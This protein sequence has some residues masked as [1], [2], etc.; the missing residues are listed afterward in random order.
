MPFVNATDSWWNTSYANRY[1]L[2]ITETTGLNRIYEPMKIN[3][4]GVS[5]SFSDKRDLR[6]VTN[7]SVEIPSQILSD[8]A[9]LVITPNIT[10]SFSGRYAYIY[11]NNPTVSKPVYTTSFLA[12]NF[13]TTAFTIYPGD[14]QSTKYQFL[15]GGLHNVSSNTAGVNQSGSFGFKV[16]KCAD[17]YYTGAGL[18][19][20]SS[21]LMLENGTLY[22]KFRCTSGTSYTEDME[23]YNG[24]QLFKFS[25][26]LSVNLC[27]LGTYQLTPTTTRTALPVRRYFNST[28]TYIVDTSTTNIAFSKGI[29]GIGANPANDPTQTMGIF[30]IYN[31][32]ALD[33]FANADKWWVE[34]RSGASEY[35]FI[36]S[37]AAD[38]KSGTANF[39]VLGSDAGKAWYGYANESDEL[40]LNQTYDKK[41]NPVSTTLGA[42]ENQPPV[43]WY[44][45]KFQYKK[46]ITI[47][48]GVN[49]RLINFTAAGIIDTQ[50]LIS[51]GKMKSDCSDI[52]IINT[53][54]I[55]TYNY[56]IEKCNSTITTLWVLFPSINSSATIYVYYG[57]SSATSTQSVANTWNSVYAGV[58]HLSDNL[59]DS[60]FTNNLTVEGAGTI[61]YITNTTCKYGGCMKFASSGTILTSTTSGFPFGATAAVQMVWFK[62]IATVTTN[63]ALFSMGTGNNNVGKQFNLN[64]G[65]NNVSY[66][67]LY[68]IN[69][70]VVASA[71][72][73]QINHFAAGLM[74]STITQSYFDGRNGTAASS[75]GSLNIADSHHLGSSPEQYAGTIWSS[76]DL[77]YVDEYRIA[78]ISLTDDYINALYLSNSTIYSEESRPQNVT[79]NTANITS[80]SLS[81]VI[82]YSGNALSCNATIVGSVTSYNVS[83]EWFKDSVSFATGSLNAT[84][85]TNTII[86]TTS[87]LSSS[88]GSI[89]NCTI[90]AT[91][92]GIIYSNYASASLE[93]NGIRAAIQNPTVGQNYTGISVPGTVYTPAPIT[94]PFN[95]TINPN[96]TTPDR[97]WYYIKSNITTISDNLT[98]VVGG[99]ANFSIQFNLSASDKY[100][101]TIYANDTAART[102]NSTNVY[103]NVATFAD[104]LCYEKADGTACDA[105]FCIINES[106]QGQ[107]CTGQARDCSDT[108]TCTTDSCDEAQDACKHSNKPLGTLCGNMMACDGTLSGCTLYK[109]VLTSPFII[110]NPSAYKDNLSTSTNYTNTEPGNLTF[111]WYSN[112]VNIYNQTFLNVENITLNRYSP[113]P[114][115]GQGPQVNATLGFLNLTQGECVN[116][117]VTAIAAGGVTSN[118]TTDLVCMPQVIN[119]T[120][121]SLT[122]PAY[123]NTTL[124]CSANTFGITAVNTV[125]WEWL[126]NSV[127]YSTGTTNINNNT[128]SEVTTLSS[129]LSNV[130]ESWTCK[131]RATPDN[132]TYTNYLEATRLILGMVFNSSR[133]AN[134]NFGNLFDIRLNTTY[135]FYDVS[136]TNF[137]LWHTT[138][139]SLSQYVYFI[140]GTSYTG[141]LNLSSF[142][143][144]T[145]LVEYELS[146]SEIYPA[147]YNMRQTEIQTILHNVSASVTGINDFLSVEFLNFS[148]NTQYNILEFMMNA[149]SGVNSM[150][151]YYCNSSFAFTNSPISNANCANIGTQLVTTPYNHTHQQYSS[152]MIFPVPLNFSTGLVNGVKATGKSYFVFRGGSATTWTMYGVTNI[153]RNGIARLTVNNGIAWTNQTFTPDS[154]VHQFY[155]DSIYYEYACFNESSDTPTTPGV[156]STIRADALDVAT[157]PPNSPIVYNPTAGSY[158]GLVNINWT[159]AT[160][161]TGTAMYAYNI[162]LINSTGGSYTIANN[163]PSNLGAS[164]CAKNIPN[165][166]YVAQVKVIDV[167]GGTALGQSETYTNNFYQTVS[168]ITGIGNNSQYNLTTLIVTC[169]YNASSDLISSFSPKVCL[170][171]TCYNGVLGLGGDF[172]YNFTLNDKQTG[173]YYCRLDNLTTCANNVSTSRVYFNVAIPPINVS[174]S[175][176]VQGTDNKNYTRTLVATG[177]VNCVQGTNPDVIMYINGIEQERVPALCPVSGLNFDYVPTNGEVFNITF[178]FS[179]VNSPLYGYANFV[180]KNTPPQINIQSPANGASY[181]VSSLP[182]PLDLNYTVSDELS[183]QCRFALDNNLFSVLGACT[184]VSGLVPTAGSHNMT[185]YSING[186]GINTT[187]TSNFTIDVNPVLAI[188]YSNYVSGTNGNYTNDLRWNVTYRCYSSNS[189]QMYI[190]DSAYLLPS[191]LT[192]DGNYNTI[193]SIGVLRNYIPTDENKFNV[194]FKFTNVNTTTLGFADFYGKLTPATINIQTPL[195][196]TSIIS[197]TLPKFVDIN[198]TVNDSISNVCWYVVNGVEY[199]KTT[200]CVNRSYSVSASGVYNITVYSNNS[201]NYVGSANTNFSIGFL[202]TNLSSYGVISSPFNVQVVYDFGVDT[203]VCDILTNTTGITCTQGV[204]PSP[205]NIICTPSIDI[206]KSINTNLSCFTSSSFNY[207]TTGTPIF[208]DTAA[209]VIGNYVFNQNNSV[210]TQNSNIT[211]QFNFTDSNLY[212][213][214]VTINGTEIYSISDINSTSYTYNLSYSVSNLNAIGRYNLTIQ[215]WDSHTAEE[216]GEYDVKKLL[217]SNELIYDTGNN[218]IK[219]KAKDEPLKLK[220]SLDTKKEKDRYTFDYD[221]TVVKESYTFDVHTEQPLTIIN[222]PNTEWK[223]WIISGN[224]WI[225]F[226]SPDDP[227]IVSIE[228]VDDYNAIVT[229]TKNGENFMKDG[230]LEFES[231]GDLNQVN[232][233]FEFY[234]GGSVEINLL[235]QNQTPAVGQRLFNATVTK[236]SGDVYNGEFSGTITSDGTATAL[237]VTNL[238]A[239]EYSFVLD[240]PYYFPETVSVTVNSSNISLTYNTAQARLSVVPR[241]IQDQSLLTNGTLRVNSTIFDVTR[242]NTINPEV[243]LLNASLYDVRYSQLGFVN[244]TLSTNLSYKD[245]ITLYVD[246]GYQINFNLL[247]E[248]TGLP[249]DLSSPNTTYLQIDCQNSVDRRLVTSNNFS[250]EI[251]CTASTFRFL[252]YWDDLSL[253]YFRS[254]ILD[255]SYIFNPNQNIY[256]IDLSTTSYVINNLFVDDLLMIYSEPSIFVR[257]WINNENVVITSDKTDIESKIV[258]YLIQNTEYIIEVHST[259]L[260]VVIL[261]NYYAADSGDK[262]L[263]LYDVGLGGDPGGNYNTIS[264]YAGN[265]VNKTFLR[266][267]DTNVNNTPGNITLYVYANKTNTTNGVLIGTVN[268]VGKDLILEWDYSGYLSSQV[269]SYGLFVMPTGTD[270][271]YGIVNVP[272]AAKPTLPFTKYLSAKQPNI[273]TWFLTVILAGIALLATIETANFVSMVL[274][275]LAAIFVAFGWFPL[276]WGILGLGIFVSLITIFKGGTR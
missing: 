50:S 41:M 244:K 124:I 186:L 51:A 129:V 266:Y 276:S 268:G 72:T 73:A 29:L 193:N 78:K 91:P 15:Q 120:S 240:S 258:A 80:V 247:N 90:R 145:S 106:C 54:N 99:C 63:A 236:L 195:P 68:G 151:V 146:E 34:S 242:T 24:N 143:N 255:D 237:T 162:T 256:L 243:Y 226:Y 104:N 53:N 85:N 206:E 105:G 31:K 184:N 119:I 48:T 40:G 210:V 10:A 213:L 131:V 60:L 94:V 216:I 181:L 229:V 27:N 138:N 201:L 1:D 202:T 66:Y 76:I 199:N 220:N 117:S 252:Q 251:N 13:S 141:W 38:G 178:G 133:P 173:Y 64:G 245:N 67:T 6:V 194:S 163:T 122:S 215:M 233:S 97:C 185:V 49:S 164:Y 22:A 165:N 87:G 230:I 17:N 137:Q 259:N 28:G 239:G 192:C 70:A 188:T 21:C 126:K 273:L 128:N 25:P 58:W 262:S 9:T 271:S 144:T 81:P 224:N 116:A 228:K 212:R 102:N 3:V 26:L 269:S 161:Q 19:G 39:T 203:A 92:D 69:A 100:N 168:D 83:F 148:T 93:I 225:D 175:G 98:S 2:N 130:G 172:S 112:N 208:V 142:T 77:S 14:S 88:I 84:N 61:S 183:V 260:P 222:K 177:T 127:S 253:N 136:A 189:L 234:L 254:F 5:C 101:I 207:T 75:G 231:I 191:S 32:T 103:F 169:N 274:L 135:N 270:T 246:L 200:S 56:E 7:M 241:N 158:G 89:W 96:G 205:Q 52:R 132:I 182:M 95:F 108:N 157:L 35:N 30:L 121:I 139:S 57:N 275:G 8:G 170:N 167:I 250:T 209:P 86:N 149:T 211:G 4:S 44:D 159:A 23:F 180:G 114:K 174:Y 42:L 37:T 196:D 190:N 12:Q 43:T 267:I 140:N 198:Y 110:P 55:D 16:A 265:D 166:N 238:T 214:N 123:D 248:Y 111:R 82:A 156:C 218:E 249:Y 176:Y 179:F 152:H 11:C 160:S 125:Q 46:N 59:G 150:T 20:S 227:S 109:N 197:F 107:I 118:I 153:V 62:P 257:K 217:L 71:T 134:I 147:T 113:T 261:G 204:G 221:P 219:I 235:N 74:N 33:G 232:I 36:F 264:Y 45:T 272:A 79:A 47:Q 115:N 18:A 171:T 155:N 65:G 223:T 187:Y 263:R 154:H